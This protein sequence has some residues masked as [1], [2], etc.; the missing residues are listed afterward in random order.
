MFEEHVLITCNSLLAVDGTFIT[1]TQSLDS[2]EKK[3][4]AKKLASNKYRCGLDF[5][6]ENN[7]SATGLTAIAAGRSER[8][9]DAAV[10][11]HQEHRGCLAVITT[12]RREIL[13]QLRDD[14]PGI[15]WPSHWSFPG[16][17]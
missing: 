11:R 15:S 16:G 3:R 12:S 9:R 13:L 6:D 1:G 4:T 2:I 14:K 7:F 8:R 10:Q 5:L 17:G